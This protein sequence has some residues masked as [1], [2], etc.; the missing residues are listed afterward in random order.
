MFHV[1]DIVRIGKGLQPLVPGYIAVDPLIRTFKQLDS[2]R[3]Y[4]AL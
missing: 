4:S 3:V 2:L 1:V